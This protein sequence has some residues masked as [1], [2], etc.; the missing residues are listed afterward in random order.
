[1]QA[2][3]TDGLVMEKQHRKMRQAA[4]VVKRTKRQTITRGIWKVSCLSG[5][6]RG[7][8]VKTLITQTVY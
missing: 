1:M 6:G 4:S 2:E 8:K 5:R 7:E 3:T